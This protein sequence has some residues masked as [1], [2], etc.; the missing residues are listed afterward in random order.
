MK[1][2]LCVKQTDDKLRRLHPLLFILI[3]VCAVYVPVLVSATFSPDG[4]A[5]D[6]SQ[7]ITLWEC[8]AGIV[9]APLLETLLFQ[10][11]AIK[12]VRRMFRLDDWAL[13]LVSAL[14]YGLAHPPFGSMAVSFFVG[15]PLAYTFVVYEDN[16]KVSCFLMVW[17]V[18][19]IK[20]LPLLFVVF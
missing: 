9:I 12:G 14:L 11:I 7:R 19:V 15:I 13:I 16:T 10:Y 5:S 17:V 2:P 20:N 1:V 18:A 3:M 4:G 8:V 6:P